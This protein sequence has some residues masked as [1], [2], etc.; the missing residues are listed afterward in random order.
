MQGLATERILGP[1]GCK[2]CFGADKSTVP[3]K[4]TTVPFDAAD[5]DCRVP[6]TQA[7]LMKGKFD[8][9]GPEAKY[10][11]PH[12]TYYVEKSQFPWSPAPTVNQR[13]SLQTLPPVRHHLKTEKCRSLSEVRIHLI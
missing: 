2:E 12:Q 4:V 8:S 5:P 9:V 3:G 13:G 6:L 11:S 7:D 1:D 10:D